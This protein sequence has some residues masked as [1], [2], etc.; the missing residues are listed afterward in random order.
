MRLR[1][2]VP[3]R[4]ETNDNDGRDIERATPSEAATDIAQRIWWSS[5]PDYFTSITIR[6]ADR[7]SK[8]VWDVE[9]RV[10]PIPD[11]IADRPRPVMVEGGQ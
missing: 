9:V 4:E 6:V 2:W 3:G 1:C 11:F 8:L 10:E 7:D 5:S